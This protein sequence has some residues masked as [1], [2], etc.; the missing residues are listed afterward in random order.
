LTASPN[1]TYDKIPNEDSRDAQIDM[2]NLYA[3]NRFPGSD[4]Y[5]NGSHV[6]YGFKFGGYQNSTGNAAF[7]T[8]GQSYRLSSD[9]P[10]PE[11]SGL[12]NDSSD[13][14]GQIETTIA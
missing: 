13:Y 14:V 4:R 5:E 8:L 12:E 9:N 1:R 11:G 7:I 10:F 6:S 2:L 3:D